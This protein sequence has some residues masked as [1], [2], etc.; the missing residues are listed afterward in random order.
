MRNLSD[1]ALTIVRQ[2]REFV[3]AP[4]WMAGSGRDEAIIDLLNRLRPLNELGAVL[5][6]A[7]F[8][9]S[10]SPAIRIEAGRVVDWMLSSRPS[11]ELLQLDIGWSD[12][13]WEYRWYVSAQWDRLKPNE[14]ASLAT[15]EPACSSILGLVSIHRNGFVRE[16]AVRQ[17]SC[18]N[19]GKELPFLLIRLNDWV[20]PIRSL[21]R[22]AVVERLT[23]SNLSSLLP[24]LPLICRLA[25]VRRNDLSDI[26]HAVVKLV[27]LP[28]HDKLLAAVLGSDDPN[29]R[30]QVFRIALDQGCDCRLLEH[31]SAS[32]DP[33]IRL[34]CSHNVRKCAV[35]DRRNSLIEKLQHD[36]VVPVRREAI[37]MRGEEY[38]ETARALW[39]QSLLDRSRSIRDMARYYLKNLEDFDFAAFYRRSLSETPDSMSALAGL[40]ETGTEDDLPVIRSYLHSP[41]PRSTLR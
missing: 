30:R 13:N 17:L 12:I 4:S 36:R 37:R 28:Q 24:N 11:T 29:V 35:R 33:I 20:E 40:C 34:F 15:E 41:I 1:A 21:A 2:L 19:D 8:L 22:A 7:K 32:V 6:V 27:V 39:I 3:A 26:L 25:R 5:D 10:T 38:P 14:I 18:H 16:E 31:G 23:E 9:F